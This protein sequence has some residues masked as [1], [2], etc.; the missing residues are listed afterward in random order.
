MSIR[1]RGC[2]GS[3]SRFFSKGNE[4]LSGIEN[5]GKKFPKL[6]RGDSFAL[7]RHENAVF[8]FFN[9][10]VGSARILRHKG[11]KAGY[12]LIVDAF[13]SQ[14]KHS[15]RCMRTYTNIC[16]DLS[17]GSAVCIIQVHHPFGVVWFITYSPLAKVRSTLFLCLFFFCQGLID[18]INALTDNFAPSDFGNDMS[19]AISEFCC[20]AFR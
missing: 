7:R 6:A 17:K 2:S 9:P 10:R 4:V 13:D 15:F 18:T 11:R 16:S 14:I 20:I 3:R 5:E 1:G 12:K 19:F 8:S